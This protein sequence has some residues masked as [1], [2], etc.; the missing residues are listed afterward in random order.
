MRQV[1]VPFRVSM[2]ALAC[3]A[4]LAACGG[5]GGSGGSEGRIQVIDFSYPGGST[6]QSDVTLK[7]TASS[8]LPVTFRSGTPSTCTVSGDKL[9][10][11]A[12]GECL[13]LASQPGGVGADG[14]KWAAAE[15]TSQLFNVLKLAQAPVLPL[16][17][18]VRASSQTLTLSATTD[19]GQ[20]ATYAS[21]TESVCTVSGNTLSFPGQGLCQ[22]T[23]TAPTDATHAALTATAFLV[24]SSMP[25]TVVQTGGKTQ[26]IALGATDAGGQALSYTSSTPAVCKVAG[27]ELQL[28]AKGTCALSLSIAG[29]ASE[30]FVVSVDP[31]FFATGY[32]A[33][34][35]RTAEFGEINFFAGVPIASWCGG[36][37]PSYCNLSLN[38]FSASF[39]FDIKPVQSSDWTGSTSNWWSYYGWDIGAPRTKVTNSDGSTGYQLQ[40]FDVPTEDSLFLTLG[41]NPELLANGGDVFVRIRT[42][43]FQK[44]ASDNSDCYVTVS[45][46][47]HPSSIAPTSYLLPFNEF[48]VTNKCEIADLPQTEGWMFDWGVSAESKAAALAEIRAHGIRAIEF[49]AGSINL[50]TP[51]PNADGSVPG[52]NDPAYTLS[53]NITVYGPITVQ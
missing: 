13:V 26:T 7:A 32:N 3:S 36:A 52:P 4:L 35:G 8:G 45:A 30:N 50:G 2:A 6:L 18:V 10:L 24:V 39:G 51:T 14:T 49:A 20:A 34:L 25:P 47:L 33:A 40:P 21:T 12:A 31:R 42:N 53:T 23:V 17:V 48:A 5:G 1:T 37:T 16:G 28:L 43:H 29:G 11:V 46:H 41:V 27:S 44:K 22:L 9:T 19:A 38:S 15:D